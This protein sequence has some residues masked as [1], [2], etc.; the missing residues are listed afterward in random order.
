MPSIDCEVVN[1]KGMHA[2][3]AAKIV[4]LVCDYQCS[5]TLNHGDKSAPGDSLI[6][7]LTLNAPKGSLIC[8]EASGDDADAFL[9]AIQLLFAEGFGE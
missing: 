9:Q 1:I 6:K 7:L 8:I 2:R 3:A 4:A 5:V